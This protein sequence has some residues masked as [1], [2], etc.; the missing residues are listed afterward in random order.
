MNTRNNEHLEA[1]KNNVVSVVIIQY[2]HCIPIYI[3][4]ARLILYL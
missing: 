4:I 2:I 1:F 3:C